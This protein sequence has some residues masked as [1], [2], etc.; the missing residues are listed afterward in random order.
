MPVLYGVF[1]YMGVSSLK[2]SQFF[3]RILIMFMPQKYQPDYMFLRHV[4]TMRV[5]LFT[6]IQ[7]TCLVCLWLIKSYKP[8]SIAFPLMLVVM[9]GV[10]K[11]LD[12][13]FTQRELKVLDDVMPEHTKKKQEEEMMKEVEQEVF[14]M[15]NALL[16]DVSSS[17]VAIALVNGNLIKVPMEK[18]PEDK[19]LPPINITEQLSQTGLWQ[20]IDQQ[21][22]HKGSTGAN[23]SSATSA[24]SAGENGARKKKRG[25]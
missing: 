10:R 4:P 2:G 22:Q 20:S 11:L 19:E 21:N 9:I 1:L 13:V 17:N 15:K 16:P 24:Q 5:H 3:D 7:L 14:E 12:F 8:S 23:A 25:K 6:L 18:Y